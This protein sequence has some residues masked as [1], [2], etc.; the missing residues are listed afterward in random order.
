VRPYR[1][2]FLVVVD[3]VD[4]FLDP[5]KL[6]FN[7]CSNKANAFSK[8]ELERY[9][10][11]SKAVYNGLPVPDVGELVSDA[12]AA[13]NTAYW[14]QLHARLAAIHVEI[15][16][17]SRSINKSFGIF[18]EQTLRHCTTNIAQDVEGYRS[19]IARPYASNVPKSKNAPRKLPLFR[20]SFW[21]SSL[22]GR[23][24]H[25]HP[26][27]GRPPPLLVV[28][29]WPPIAIMAAAAA[30]SSSLLVV[31]LRVIFR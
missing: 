1:E 11:V 26:K 23:Q 20:L 29:W 5:D 28:W 25:H 30:R 18:N 19:L 15:Q 3:E 6:V 17:K 31:L 12:A 16:D 2:H 7:I 10:Q 27:A 9:Y 4:D 14:A 24:H 13:N 22:T 8:G 21:L